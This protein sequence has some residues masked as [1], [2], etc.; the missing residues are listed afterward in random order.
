MLQSEKDHPFCTGGTCV[1]TKQ[2]QIYGIMLFYS[3]ASILTAVLSGDLTGTFQGFLKILSSPAQLTMDYFKLGT[4]GGTFLNVGMTGL[5]CVVVFALSRFAVNGLSL[6]SF[7]LTIGFSFFGMNFLNFWPCILGTWVFTRVAKLPFKAQVNIAIFSTSLSPFVSEGMWRHPAVDSLFARVLFGVLL[8]L[9]C[10]FLMPILA[11][12]GPNLHKG[13]SLYNAASVAG[14]IGIML[15]AFLFRAT[16][17][18]IPSN[19]DIGDSHALVVNAYALATSLVMV[20]AGFLLNGRSFKGF[21]HLLTRSSA[22]RCD[23]TNSYSAPVTMINIGMF[24]L[25]VTAYYN[26]IGAGM[27]GPTAGSIICLLAVTPCGTH[28]FNMIPMILGYGL[29]SLFC[30]FDLTTQAI[31]VGLCFC[32]A[33]S[34]IPSRFGSLSGV[35][36]GLLHAVLVTSVVTFHGG[37]CLYNGGFTAGITAIILVPVLEFFLEATDTPALLP[38]LKKR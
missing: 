9:I 30:A 18:E 32:A 37:F 1:E 34:P 15:F 19:T 6:M 21:L 31:V 12:H 13:Y 27:T 28:I 20:V 26:L 17:F 23:F 2:K 11:Q 24:G 25:F 36:A 8:G 22:Y 14:F 35:I 5:S 29:A 10:G 4:V 33:L 38:T 16:G 7:F 3:L